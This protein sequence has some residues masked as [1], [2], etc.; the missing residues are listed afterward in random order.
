MGMRFLRSGLSRL[1]AFPLSRQD[2]FTCRRVKI[3]SDL[4]QVFIVEDFP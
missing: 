4:W 3:L 1:E 2:L